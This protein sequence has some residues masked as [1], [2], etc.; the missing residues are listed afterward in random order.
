MS[1][2]PNIQRLGVD[3]GGTFVDSVVFDQSTSSMEIG[4]EPTTPSNL[5]E[6]VFDAIESVDPNLEEVTSLIH[7]TT[8]GINAILE[9]EGSDVGLIT[10]EGFKDVLEIGRG[11][12]P[13]KEMYNIQYDPPKQLVPRRRRV[14]VPQRMNDDG[15]IIEPLDEEAVQDSA[16]YLIQE[17]DVDAIAIC[18][19]HSYQNPQHEERAAE[20]IQENHPDISVSVSSEIMREY[21]EFE[22]TST[23]ALDGY[24]KPL[25]ESYI[26]RMENQLKN[27]GFD[28]SIQITRSGGGVLPVAE[29]ESRPIHTVLSGPAGGFIGAS[30]LANKLDRDNIIAIDIGG[31]SVDACVIQ[32]G[33][34]DTT[35]K[36]T[37]E[38]YPIQLPLYD[39]RTIGAG[40]GSIAWLDGDLLKVGP[41]S[42]GADPGPICYD[43]GGTEPTV[44]DAAV[45]LGYIDPDK[46]LGGEM[47]L[48]EDKASEGIEQNISEPLDQTNLESSRGILDVTIA[49]IT[50]AI[51]EIT[52]EKGLDPRD[53]SLVAYGG[54]GPMLMPLLAREIETKETIIPRAPSVFSAWGMLQADATFDYT[55]TVTKLIENIQADWMENAFSELESEATDTLDDA[56]LPTELR[57][58]ERSVEMRYFGQG[59]SVEVDA[60]GIESTDELSTKFDRNHEMRYGHRMEDPAEVVNL[61]VRAIGEYDKPGL[62]EPEEMEESEQAHT[63]SK[64]AYCF[65]EQRYTKFE[66]Y[67]RASLSKDREISGPSIVREPTTTIVFYS[68][69]NSQ[70]DQFGNLL[71]K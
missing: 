14:E 24:I 31:T 13:K 11:N 35:Y 6:G 7:G 28:G 68:D 38:T 2:S 40:G 51:R 21:R 61:R 39:I 18:F 33:S 41:Q 47:K 49:N 59:H 27:G 42:A 9:R 4:K 37:F 36:T 46:F 30:Y 32:D 62:Q 44:T 60:N 69:Q 48:D 66:T 50:N 29:A 71:I 54:A 64:E 65:A 22:R 58:L 53:F 26:E 34:P 55:Q 3:I 8:V 12:V 25:F 19:L 15:E 16:K 56:G 20:L 43:R 45:E 23:T 17:H 70:V 1:K 57:R 63:G 67:D 52:V 5:V 10:T